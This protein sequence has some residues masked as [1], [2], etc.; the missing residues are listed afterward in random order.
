MTAIPDNLP[1]VEPYLDELRRRIYFGGREAPID[2]GRATSF[3]PHAVSVDTG[4][5]H[6]YAD[7]GTH[8]DEVG[9]VK[10]TVYGT[11]TFKDRVDSGATVEI[12]RSPA[13]RLQFD[14]A[15]VGAW[16]RATAWDGRSFVE[17]PDG[18]RK[19]VAAKVVELVGDVDWAKLAEEAQAAAHAHEVNRLLADARGAWQKATDLRQRGATIL[20]LS[21]NDV[22][23]GV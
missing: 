19:R 2:L 11:M 3:A 10:I 20:P 12:R 13:H 1:I 16:T 4:V 6:N 14:T 9:Y 21:R 18:A 5:I 17:L 8:T 7:D 15:Q 22:A 23:T